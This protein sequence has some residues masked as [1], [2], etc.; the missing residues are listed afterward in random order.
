M[1]TKTK[2]R[3]MTV[4]MPADVEQQ[5]RTLSEAQSRTLAAQILHYIKQGIAKE[6]KK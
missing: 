4:R 1:S 2:D 5:L 3:Y 6:A